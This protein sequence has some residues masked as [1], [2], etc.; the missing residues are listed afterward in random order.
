MKQEVFVVTGKSKL[1]GRRVEVSSRC[2]YERAKE[3]RDRM[4]RAQH[5]RSAYSHLRV[6][7]VEFE[8]CF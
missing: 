1:D 4:V 6:E 2:S 3:A 8:I 5:G 7:A